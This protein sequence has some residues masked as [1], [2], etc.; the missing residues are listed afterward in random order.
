MRDSSYNDYTQT[1]QI[2]SRGGEKKVM[3]KSLSLLLALTLVFGLFASMASAADAPALSTAEKYQ[4]FVDTGILKGKPDGKPHLEDKLTRAEFATIATAVAGLTVATS[5]QTFSDVKKGQWYYGAIEA[6]AKAGLVNGIGAGKFGPKINVTIESIIKVAVGIAGLKPVAGATVA[7][8]SVWAGPYVQAALD[9]GLIVSMPSYKGQAT[10]EN[11]IVIAFAV[12]NF[13]AIPVLGDVTAT[14]NAD[15]TITVTGKVTGTADSVK[16]ALGTATAV[17]ATLKADKTFTYTTAKQ[18]AGTYKLTVVAYEGTKAS[19]A[20]EKSATVDGFQV[21]SVTAQNSKQIVIKFNKAVQ[22][23]ILAGGFGYKNAGNL[24]YYQLGLTPTYPSEVALSDDKTTVTLTFLNPFA[25]NTIQQLLVKNLKSASG[26]TLAEY[27]QSINLTD[28]TAAS[29]T[30][31]SYTGVVAKVEFSEPV[32]TT[33]GNQLNASVSVNGIQVTNVGTINYVAAIDTKGYVTLSF[34]GLEAGKSYALSLIAVEDLVG[35][36]T[37]LTST[38]AVPTD[39]VAP[40]VTSVTA[41]GEKIRIKFSEP[42]KLSTIDGTG[43]RSVKVSASAVNAVYGTAVTDSNNEI[44]VDTALAGPAWVGSTFLTTSITISGYQDESGNAGANATY[45]IT[46]T[47][48]KTAPAVV[49][50]V[51]S[52]NK[53]I[54]KLNEDVAVGTLG[55]NGSAQT[56][57]FAHTS[58]DSVRTTGTFNTVV[59]YNYDANANGDPSGLPD[60]GEKQYIVLDVTASNVTGFVGTAL[61]DGKYELT[62]P[63]GAITDGANA[64]TAAVTVIAI[65]SGNGAASNAVVRLVVDNL[66]TVGIDEGVQQVG[67]KLIFTFNNLL[68]SAALDP[69]KFLINGTAL[70]TGTN[71]YFQTTRNV[72][73]AELPSGAIPVNGLRTV[74]VVN[75]SDENGNVLDTST[76]SFVQRDV[77]LNENLKPSLVS[78]KVN[79]DTMISVT[80]SESVTAAASGDQGFEIWIN[81]VKVDT[82]ATHNTVDTVSGTGT[83]VLTFTL[84]SANTFA[85]GQVVKIKAVSSTVADAKLNTV[86][87]G[88]VTA[89]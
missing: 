43:N 31:V 53:I 88:E 86:T 89:N 10:R 47:K 85:P 35:N 36:R 54:I 71:L 87:D 41:A 61:K 73:V 80:L 60:T 77:S 11:V 76:A 8:A 81:G 51:V 50:G 28:T 30:K 17:A 16:V 46:L 32:K 83:N 82:S 13:K 63:I 66:G 79:S 59:A 42:V 15:D 3:K 39:S 24:E 23:G 26:Q 78:A 70:P 48:D 14:V 72:V 55:A 21:S 69:N 7:G 2:H 12:A 4:W 1:K 56:V 57:A 19:A 67:S 25:N 38:L 40:T 75:I 22:E 27:K 68:T 6:A 58:T 45:T 33:G 74:K 52:G 49:S 37:D 18:A 29:I 64:N 62:L 9:A 20:V 84:H 34:N 5:G 44:V 65:V